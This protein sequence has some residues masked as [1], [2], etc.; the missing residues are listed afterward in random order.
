MSSASGKKKKQQKLCNNSEIT[1]KATPAK[2]SNCLPDW[3]V[4]GGVLAEMFRDRKYTHHDGRLIN[5]TVN[6][7]DNYVCSRS[8]KRVV[9]LT[10]CKDDSTDVKSIIDTL[11]D[12]VECVVVVLLDEEEVSKVHLDIER[13]SKR[14]VE[15]WSAC[16]L[17][18]PVVRHESQPIFTIIENHQLNDLKGKR[19]PIMSIYDKV[20]RYYRY[21]PGTVVAATNKTTGKTDVRTVK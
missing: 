9:L 21:A 4:V 13:K 14:R 5:D 15:F 6:T 3:N 19:L 11:D 1:V 12:D 8:G 2:R 16:D 10:V 7:V 17:N 18:I 20:A